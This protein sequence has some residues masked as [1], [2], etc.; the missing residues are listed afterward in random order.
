MLLINEKI[1]GFLKLPVFIL[2][3]GFVLAP[4]G[5]Y[6]VEY[7]TA[8]SEY[9]TISGSSTLGDWDMKGRKIE[10]KIS[11]TA[12]GASNAEALLKAASEGKANLKGK[13]KIPAKS[14]KSGK[15]GMDD[16]AYEAL[17]ADQHGS[18]TMVIKKYK[19]TGK[20]KGRYRFI[21]TTDVTIAGKTRS[22]GVVVYVKALDGNKLKFDAYKRLK[23]TS[24][25]IE[26]PTAML[27]TIS[28]G[29]KIKVGVHSKL[30]P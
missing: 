17:K 20:S 6:S 9:V 18:I 19:F 8:G 10:G 5:L 3:T 4:A 22:E 27:G 14:L 15:D 13:F 16:K 25:G 11:L 23:M 21:A 28:A 7:S 30:S 26:P 12:P 29:D 24:Y 1:K 2:A